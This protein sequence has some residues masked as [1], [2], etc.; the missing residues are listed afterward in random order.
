MAG[1]PVAPSVTVPETV[2]CCAD[3]RKE[4]KR[5]LNTVAIFNF[6]DFLF[7]FVH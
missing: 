2:I 3:K 1:S 7:K 4:Q 5:K 6:M